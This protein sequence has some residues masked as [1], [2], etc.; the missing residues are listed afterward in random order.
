MAGSLG[1][2]ADNPGELPA[3]VTACDKG[4]L[5]F[6]DLEDSHSEVRK[7]LEGRFSIRRRA[8]LGTQP[9]VFYLV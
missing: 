8:G 7:L 2:H 4:A 3:C 1:L 9:E 6:G 5:T